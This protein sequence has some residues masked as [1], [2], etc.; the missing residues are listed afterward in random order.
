MF[1]SLYTRSFAADGFCPRFSAAELFPMKTIR[2]REN[3]SKDD[4]LLAFIVYHPL[5]Y[6]HGT[7]DVSVFSII[8]V[9]NTVQRSFHQ[10][11]LVFLPASS[12]VG[13]GH[14]SSAGH[15]PLT[16]STRNTQEEK[17]RDLISRRVC[18]DV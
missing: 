16:F 2:C 6:L 13:A 18:E 14:I 8:I 7:D 15:S 9:M 1:L 10:K 17:T 12:R 5:L 3:N 11:S 4:F